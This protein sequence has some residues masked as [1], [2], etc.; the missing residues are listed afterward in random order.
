MI[1]AFFW[2]DRIELFLA[3]R[4]SSNYIA[5]LFILFFFA[6]SFL[7]IRGKS[8][9]YDEPYHYQYGMKIL[10]GDSTRFDDSKMPI[11]VWNALPAKLATYLPDGK[12]KVNLGKMITARLMTTLFSMAVAFTVFHWSRK[13]YGIIPALVS[14]GLYVFDPNIIAHSQLITTDIYIAGMTLICCYWLWKFA[15]TSRWQ[16]GLMFSAMLGFAQITKYTAVSLYALFAIAF[17]VHDWSR[18]RKVVGTEGRVGVW[19]EAGRYA[20]YF[21]VVI[22]ISLVIINIGFIFNRTFTHL[23][24]Y[25]FKSALFQSIQSKANFDV[26][27]PYPF[28]EGFD[29]I[30]FKE[31]TNLIFVYI[32]LLGQTRFGAGFAGYYIIAS[33]L[34]VP[35]ATQVIIW[36]ALGVYFLNAKRRQSFMKDEWFLLC[37]VLFYTVYFNFF[38]KAQIGL[39]YYLIVFPLLYVFVGGLFKDWRGFTRAQKGLFFAL[40]S[41]LIASVFSYYPNYLAYFNELVPDR[42]MAYEYLADSNLDWG[43]D[44]LALKEY[45]HE[46]RDVKKA[47]EIPS[48]FAKATTYYVS[49]NRLVGVINGPESY[50]WLRE[51]FKPVGMIA[52]SYLLFEITPDQIDHLC[53][54]TNYC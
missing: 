9:T 31:R 39:R 27:T 47:P 48:R 50:A 53:I 19:K 11:S 52:P 6:I 43:Q 1:P 5:V 32:Y 20:K 15:N 46:H 51:N 13:L 24:D 30:Y 14:L 44:E 23:K 49:V 4:K 12:L 17:L 2:K 40:A 25:Q 38:Y 26:P 36:M 33:L 34:K 3:S 10:N 8:L 37:L 18:L 45:Q 42:K 7:S 35:I 21:V 29:F 28:L 41:Y 54:T 16:D 22:A